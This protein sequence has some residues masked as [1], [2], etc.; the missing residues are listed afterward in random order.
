MNEI[1]QWPTGGLSAALGILSSLNLENHLVIDVGAHEGETAYACHAARLSHMRCISIEPNPTAFAQL[2]HN[3]QKLADHNFDIEFLRSAVGNEVGT[4]S[5]VL[6]DQSAVAG[7]LEPFAGVD[8]RVPTGDHRVVDRINVEV[9]SIDSLLLDRQITHV[10]LLKIDTEGFDLEV[11]RGAID[12]LGNN[13][14]SVIICEVFFV[15]YRNNQCFFW[16]IATFLHQLGYFFV[17][18]YDTRPTA[19]GRLYTGNGIWVSPQVGQSLGYL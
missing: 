16:D 1:D 11:L 18:L 10:H 3:S 8:E 15:N 7:L 17:N 12:V 13:A 14:V 6:T 2:V 4:R 5:F 9:V 19:Q